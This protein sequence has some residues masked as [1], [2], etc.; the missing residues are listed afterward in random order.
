MN[1]K[2]QVATLPTDGEAQVYKACHEGMKQFLFS[3]TLAERKDYVKMGYRPHKV[4]ITVPQEIESIEEG[5]TYLGDNGVLIIRGNTLTAKGRKIIA[6]DDTRLTVKAEQAGDNVW[7]NPIPQVQQS[8]LKEFVANPDGEYVVE[9][10]S[11]AAGE[12]R[13]I[14]TRLKVDK[15]KLNQYNTVNIISVDTIQ[16][17]LSSDEFVSIQQWLDTQSREEWASKEHVYDSLT[18]KFK[19]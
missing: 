14:P 8:F 15:L 1:Q 4:Y 10:E 6:T 11:V 19:M 5:E 12:I 3:D 2:I 13:G 7:M 17:D 16:V 9:Y 18:T